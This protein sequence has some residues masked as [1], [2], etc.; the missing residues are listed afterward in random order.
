M[1]PLFDQ[2]Y[3]KFRDGFLRGTVVL[4]LILVSLSHLG[5]WGAANGSSCGKNLADRRDEEIEAALGSLRLR[6]NTGQNMLNRGQTSPVTAQAIW[7]AANRVLE[8]RGHNPR[9]DPPM[10]IVD[11]QSLASQL[12][13]EGTIDRSLPPVES[14]SRRP[15]WEIELTQLFPGQKGPTSRMLFEAKSPGRNPVQ[16]LT[17]RAV[18]RVTLV[19]YGHHFTLYGA[20]YYLQ[21]SSQVPRNMLSRSGGPLTIELIGEN[22]ARYPKLQLQN[23]KEQLLT[24]LQSI[25]ADE[26][27]GQEI[28]VIMITDDPGRLW[29]SASSSQFLEA[30]IRQS[31]Q[32]SP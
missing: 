10:E 6:M 20:L 22:G 23:G 28:P 18:F 32:N 9:R 5:N 17:E 7:D 25:A 19:S 24:E 11:A 1:L 29:N 16:K 31:L 13:P 27:P 8:L 3:N 2:V 30:A 15:R 12:D 21:I 14:R 4:P 26:T